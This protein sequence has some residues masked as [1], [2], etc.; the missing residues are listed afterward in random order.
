MMAMRLRA[1][2]RSIG[3]AFRA[4]LMTKVNGSDSE[5]SVARGEGNTGGRCKTEV[6]E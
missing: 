3:S 2:L 1:E 6:Q 5:N 4:L